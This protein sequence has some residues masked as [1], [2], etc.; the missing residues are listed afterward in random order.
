MK[1]RTKRLLALVV[2]AVLL[3]LLV[4]AVYVRLVNP[5]SALREQVLQPGSIAVR[6]LEGRW[7]VADGSIVGYR[8]R[9]QIGLSKTEGVGRTE[10]IEGAFEISGEILVEAVFTVDMATLL[11]DRSQRDDQVRSRILETATFPTAIFE[12]TAPVS[13]LGASSEGGAKTQTI[14]GNLTLRGVTKYVQLLIRATSALG[15][16]RL[17]GDTEVVFSEWGIPNPSLPAALIFTADRGLL[18]FDLLFEPDL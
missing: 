16:L 9:E 6:D 5:P 10:A 17:T 11:S 15:Q 12:L 2:V 14:G 1:K 3:G 18:E 13:L 7:R 4:P 8:V